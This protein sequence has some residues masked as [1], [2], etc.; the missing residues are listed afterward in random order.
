MTGPHSQDAM[1]DPVPHGKRTSAR[2]PRWVK[3]F[4]A[5]AAVLVI[6]FLAMHLFGGGMSHL[7]MNDH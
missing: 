5:A 1:T 2:M 4:I 3:V 6:A 7:H